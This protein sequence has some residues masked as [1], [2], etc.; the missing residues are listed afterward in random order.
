MGRLARGR[1]QAALAAGGRA[2]SLLA[3]SLGPGRELGQS[4]AVAGRPAAAADWHSRYGCRPVLLET[5]VDPE[6]FAE[7]LLARRQ[8]AAPGPDPGP[9]RRGADPQGRLRVPLG[10][11]LP[12]DPAARAAPPPAQAATP[13]RAGGG[14]PRRDLRPHVAGPDRRAQ[15]RRR[16]PRPALASAPARAQHPFMLNTVRPEIGRMFREGRQVLDRPGP[17]V[18]TRVPVCAR[19][20]FRP[21]A[22]DGDRRIGNLPVS[23]RGGRRRAWPG[24][25]A[26]GGSDRLNTRVPGTDQQLDRPPAAIPERPERK[27]IAH[28]G[29][30]LA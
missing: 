10:E 29:A 15:R 19:V 26:G 21:G 11:A 3:V 23:W 2:A 4:C 17:S 27:V 22:I 13:A 18:R 14:G 6:R 20:E 16:R 25:A 5:F 24:P 12:R 30:V 7:S 28:L 9:P 8:L 1:V